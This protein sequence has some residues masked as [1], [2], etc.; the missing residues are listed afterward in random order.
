MT[1]HVASQK[2]VWNFSP[3]PAVLPLEALEEAQRDLL[4]LPGVGASVLEISHRSKIFESIIQA[5]EDNIRKLLKIPNNYFVLFLQGGARLQFGMIPLN[6][7]RQTGKT[8][9]F[10]VTGSWGAMALKEAQTQGPVRAI[11]DGK[12]EGYR[13][14]P[15]PEEYRPSPDAAYVHFTSNE[16]I[17]GV[18]FRVEPEVGDL[19]LVC[20]ASSDFL[21]RPIPIERYALLY[22]GAQK[23][24]GPAGV[25][26][27]I[28]RDDLVRRCP[29]D[30]PSMLNYR[31]HAEAKSLLNTPPCFAVYMVKLVTDWLLRQFGD[32][33]KVHEHN[34]RKAA[35]LY[36]VIDHSNGYYRGHAHP[37]HRSLMNVTFRLPNESLEKKFVSEADKAGFMHLEGHRS[38]GGCRASI[39]NAMPIEGVQALK[40]FMI[41][42]QKNNPA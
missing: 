34:Q 6:F 9:E 22:A 33:Q 28:I 38:V 31:K 24:A 27:V 2:R 5:A 29:E 3:G 25:T 42:F 1:H 21:S 37:E 14:V 17:E 40:E 19:P 4:A 30:L 41:E 39:Y 12:A 32:L 16:T 18:Q 8:A 10:I 11:W 13:R 23:N 35:I 20:D 7:L 15:R 26:I 36:E